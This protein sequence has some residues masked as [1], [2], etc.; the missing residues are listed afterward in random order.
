MVAGVAV[1]ATPAPV[2]RAS[3]GTRTADLPLGPD[4]SFTYTYRQS[5]YQVT[6][7]EEQHATGDGLE[8][9]RVRSVDQRAVEYFRWPG[10]GRVEGG[11]VVQE[12]PPNHVAALSIEVTAD[13]EQRLAAN[14][15]SLPLLDT[16]GEDVVHVVPATVSRANWLLASFR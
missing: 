12:A 8:I 4:Q 9:V 13:A 1:L 15:R 16:F 11:E 5:I 10:E 2:L 3:S 6:V 7:V 14:G